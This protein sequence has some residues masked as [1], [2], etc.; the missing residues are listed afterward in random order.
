MLCRVFFLLDGSALMISW[1]GGILALMV[2]AMQQKHQTNI[3]ID[4]R[5][6][7]VMGVGLHRKPCFLDAR[8]FQG[9]P[10]WGELCHCSAAS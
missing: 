10:S 3:R 6:W 1:V 9:T 2:I 8:V 7:L 4:A 5:N